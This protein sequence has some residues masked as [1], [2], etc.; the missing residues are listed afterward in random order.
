MRKSPSISCLIALNMFRKPWY[1]RPLLVV[2]RLISVLHIQYWQR[3]ITKGGRGG[4]NAPWK[5][6]Q[7]YVDLVRTEG[8]QW[9]S[10]SISHS[11]IHFLTFILVFLISTKIKVIQLCA[12]TN[13]YMFNLFIYFQLPLCPFF[14]MHFF[15]SDFH[16]IFLFCQLLWY[17]VNLKICL[18]HLIMGWFWITVFAC[19]AENPYDKEPIIL[20]Y[21]L[22]ILS[23]VFLYFYFCFLF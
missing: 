12:I 5:S 15:S 8:S 16:Y 1:N 7:F 23:W 19:L 17:C 3:R 14:C 22:N 20:V 18:I 4:N 2:I 11:Q 9:K 13:I 10:L 21:W 6:L